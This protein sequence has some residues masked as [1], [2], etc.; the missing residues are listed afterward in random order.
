MSDTTRSRRYW[1]SSRSSSTRCRSRRRVSSSSTTEPSRRPR[2]ARA[3]R[4]WA[5][6][7]S[8]VVAA[9]HQEG[10]AH[11]GAAARARRGARAAGAASPAIRP[12]SGE[13]SSVSVVSPTQQASTIGSTQRAEVGTEDGRPGPR[14]TT[15]PPRAP[16]T[17]PRRTSRRRLRASSRPA[18]PRSTRAGRGRRA[19]SDRVV[20]DGLRGVGEAQVLDQH[21]VLVQQVEREARLVG[22]QLD[23]V[24]G[25]RCRA[26]R[27]R[28][29]RRRSG[30]RPDRR[31]WCASGARSDRRASAA[32]DLVGD[33]DV[34][35]SPP[36]GHV[37]TTASLGARRGSASRSARRQRCPVGVTS[38]GRARTR[39]R[40]R[41]TRRRRRD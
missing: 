8:S 4:S 38:G 25:A 32:S 16:R 23:E 18:A 21:M 11:A 9:Q 40:P 36:R 1:S 3:A 17:P 41:A 22:V 35:Q 7:G 34:G 39:R 20:Q 19:V 2:P 27:P 28:P 26:R 33:L 37:E 31:R 13:S 29:G 24:A 10:T 30:R 6:Q 15:R 14:G 12:S 5:V